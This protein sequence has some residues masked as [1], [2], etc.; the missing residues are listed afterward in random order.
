MHKQVKPKSKITQIPA[1]LTKDLTLQILTVKRDYW[2][3]RTEGYA[4]DE[5][6]DRLIA[7][8]EVHDFIHA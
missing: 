5:N 8:T 1:K 7:L 6:I 2:T 4:D 3:D